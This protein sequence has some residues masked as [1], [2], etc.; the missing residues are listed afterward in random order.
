MMYSFSH[1]TTMARNSRGFS[2]YWA[3][4]KLTSKDDAVKAVETLSEFKIGGKTVTMQPYKGGRT[5]IKRGRMGILR[6]TGK[7][8][9]DRRGDR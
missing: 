5:G 8:P 1:S 4:V 9:K 7:W 6:W 3:L 2:A